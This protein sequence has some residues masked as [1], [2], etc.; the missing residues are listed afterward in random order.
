MANQCVEDHGAFGLVLWLELRTHGSEVKSIVFI[1]TEGWETSV[2][3][4][5]HKERSVKYLSYLFWNWAQWPSGERPPS[6]IYMIKVVFWAHQEEYVL[7][8]P[9][10]L[11]W[12]LNSWPCG[13]ILE[14]SSESGWMGQGKEPTKSDHQ[15]YLYL[16]WRLNPQSFDTVLESASES[17][18]SEWSRNR[19]YQKAEPRTESF[20][21]K[22]SPWLAALIR[23]VCFRNRAHVLH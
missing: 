3:E 6:H 2:L 16:F 14:S 7:K 13:K 9:F 5:E 4:T 11:F 19:A 17:G 10:S 21:W 18:W 20:S 23:I 12:E 1:R 8:I 15:K 22:L